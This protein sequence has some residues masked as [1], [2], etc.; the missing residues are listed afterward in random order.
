MS[1]LGEGMPKLDGTHFL[2]N[3]LFPAGQCAVLFSQD[4]MSGCSL[5]FPLFTAV[6]IL[7]V[8]SFVNRLEEG[9]VFQAL[10]FPVP[11]ADVRLMTWS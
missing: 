5:S 7:L 8:S 11:C 4:A 9:A 10:M 3:L 2:Y 6:V 1:S